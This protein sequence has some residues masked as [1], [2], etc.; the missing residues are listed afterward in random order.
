MVE[1][2]VWLI[3]HDCEGA[4]GVRYTVVSRKL[5]KTSYTVLGD[6]TNHEFWDATKRQCMDSIASTFLNSVDG[7][8]DHWQRQYL[9]RLQ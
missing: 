1:I 6:F 4:E 8:L 5:V 7:T 2:S 3:G 9:G